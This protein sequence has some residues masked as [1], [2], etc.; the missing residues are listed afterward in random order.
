M[1]C[2]HKRS[3]PEDPIALR[4]TGQGWVGHPRTLLAFV[5][6]SGAAGEGYSSP[7]SV[8]SSL[9]VPTC[10]D[11]LATSATPQAAFP[12]LHLPS[13]HP[14]SVEVF[15]LFPTVERLC[16]SARSPSLLG[17]LAQHRAVLHQLDPPR[18]PDVDGCRARRQPRARARD[19][20]VRRGCCG[21]VSPGNSTSHRRR[22][23]SERRR[24]RG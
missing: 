5:T 4:R 12:S 7:R 16:H 1:R 19:Q 2:T 8:P 6:Q 15:V 3:T 18:L 14:A 17:G 24:L 11:L 21:R 23:L 13:P 20:P 9:V 22:P 10:I